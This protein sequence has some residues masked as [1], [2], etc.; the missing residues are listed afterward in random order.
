MIHSLS[1]HILVRLT[2]KTKDF[3][4]KT[5][6]FLLFLQQI[7]INRYFTPTYEHKITYTQDIENRQRD[8][9]G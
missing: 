9:I 2:W 5:K 4:L 1:Q 3:G 7:K 6:N 8:V